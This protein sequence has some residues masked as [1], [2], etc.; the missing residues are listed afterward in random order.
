MNNRGLHTE[1]YFSDKIH[2]SLVD[3]YVAWRRQFPRTSKFNRTKL[4]TSALK[5]RAKYCHIDLQS[6][7]RK[8]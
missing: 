5:F 4:L 2:A 7:K 6:V 3:D 8:S 1:R